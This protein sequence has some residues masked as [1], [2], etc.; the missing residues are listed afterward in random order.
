M[1]NIIVIGDSKSIENFD[2]IGLDY[3]SYSS[4]RVPG[5]RLASAQSNIKNSK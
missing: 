3:V 1:N 4:F 5:A 2:R